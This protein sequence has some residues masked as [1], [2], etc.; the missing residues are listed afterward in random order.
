[1][2][3]PQTTK[4]LDLVL[5]E[6]DELLEAVPFDPSRFHAHDVV[7]ENTLPRK[8]ILIGIGQLR[9]AVPMDGVE[10]VGYLPAI[11]PLPNLPA[12]VLGII[13]VRSEIVAV[14]DLAGFL[15]LKITSP[16]RDTRY[17][18]IHHERIKA[19]IRM[20]EI[21]GTVS[22][23]IAE[24]N[25]PIPHEIQRGNEHFFAS[26]GFRVDNQAY[27]ILDVR[28]IFSSRRFLNLHQ[29]GLL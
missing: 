28:E 9:I 7:D 22:K 27:C 23:S 29:T 20:D 15:D 2:E 1:M 11:T 18:I 8:F 3:N 16:H 13:N 10:E 19:A 4:T 14:I 25:I 17:V 24:R 21:I 6:I 12:W 5:Q 26:V